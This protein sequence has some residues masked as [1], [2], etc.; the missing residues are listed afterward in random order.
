MRMDAGRPTGMWA[1][2]TFYNP[3][4]YQSRR[5]NYRQFRQRLN[6]PLVA[7]ELSFDGTFELTANDA[8]ILIQKSG[9]DV[10]WQKER[11]LNIALDALPDECDA[12]AWL[13]C[14]VVFRRTD[15]ADH[16]RRE[17]ETVPLVQPYSMVHHLPKGVLP[18][19]WAIR[20]MGLVRPSVAW[21]IQQGMPAKECLANPVAG[22]PGI[23]AP[24]HA[25]VARREL[26]AQQRFYDACIIGGGDTALVCA[27]YGEFETLPTLHADNELSFQHYLS[28]A[29]PFFERVQGQVSV[30][31]GDLLH[32]WHG[33]MNDR[34]TRRRHH[35]LSTFNFDPAVDIAIGDDGCWRWNSSKWAMHEYVADYFFARN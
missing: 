8:D 15:W 17:L 16:A 14:D 13:D 28:W 23:R 1:I 3:A 19:Q 5:D 9:G 30:A 34:R 24:G 20:P 2:T 25:W 27:A 18:E 11:L 26:L 21:L 32:L 29:G 22:F 10:M 12:V 31:K 33:E 6:L 35:E 4:R 7:V